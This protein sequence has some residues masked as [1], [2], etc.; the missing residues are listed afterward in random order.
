LPDRIIGAAC[1]VVFLS[2]VVA[3][4]WSFLKDPEEGIAAGGY[5]LTALSSI[6]GMV[7]LVNALD[8]VGS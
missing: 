7:S 8:T 1:S 3:L 2:F 6:I 4:T 5:V